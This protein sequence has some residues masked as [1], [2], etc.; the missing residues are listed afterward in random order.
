MKMFLVLVKFRNFLL[1]ISNWGQEKLW[2]VGQIVMGAEN[3][4]EENPGEENPGEENPSVTDLAV[5]PNE[6][7]VWGPWGGQYPGVTAP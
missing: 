1:T 4:G 2:P 7:L 5:K 3:P 6:E